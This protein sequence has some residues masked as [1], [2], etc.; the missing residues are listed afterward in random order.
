LCGR[1]LRGC[2]PAST[3]QHL[4]EGTRSATRFAVRTLVVA[5]ATITF[6]LFASS[7]A[8]AQQTCTTTNQCATFDGA[9]VYQCI[10]RICQACSSA[11]CCLSPQCP[12]DS[13]GLF[14]CGE[15]G[16]CAVCTGTGT[17][18]CC[19]QPSCPTGGCGVFPDNCGNM[20]V[21]CG[22]CAAP[23]TCGGGG[24]GGLCGCTPLSCRTDGVCGT[25][26]DGCGGTVHC[27]P[28][29]TP[30]VPTSIL[31]LFAVG[32]LGVG[33]VGAIKRRLRSHA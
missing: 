25:L 18:E 13:R 6:A 31:P 12:R 4:L 33:I 20:V 16:T 29:P 3:A 14:E 26:P 10:N 17:T 1:K 24:V 22:G 11:S 7:A 30:A 5:L 19:A 27:N 28:C 32:L 21:N 9:Q 15:D 23:N 2:F 8:H